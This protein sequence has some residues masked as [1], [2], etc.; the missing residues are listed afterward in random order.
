[1]NMYKE[2]SKFMIEIRRKSKNSYFEAR[3]KERLKKIIES[4]KKLAPKETRTKKHTFQKRVEKFMKIDPKNYSQSE[5]ILKKLYKSTNGKIRNLELLLSSELFEKLCR[6]YFETAD[7]SANQKFIFEDIIY[8]SQKILLN[9]FWEDAFS[10]KFGE[11][12]LGILEEYVAKNGKSEMLKLPGVWELVDSICQDEMSFSF[13]VLDCKIFENCWNSWA[14]IEE[15]DFEVSR[16]RLEEEIEIQIRVALIVSRNFEIFLRAKGQISLKTTEKCIGFLILVLKNLSTFFCTIASEDGFQIAEKPAVADLGRRLVSNL[17][18]DLADLVIRS[19]TSIIIFVQLGES[20]PCL[21]LEF[22]EITEAMIWYFKDYYPEFV[23][24]FEARSTLVELERCYAKVLKFVARVEM[25][26]LKVA[27]VLNFDQK[28]VKDFGQLKLPQKISLLEFLNLNFEI[29]IEC[30]LEDLDKFDF[31]WMFEFSLSLGDLLE[32]KSMQAKESKQDLLFCR[33]T[34]ILYMNFLKTSKPD[35]FYQFIEQ[36]K[37]LFGGFFETF[38][39]VELIINILVEIVHVVTTRHEAPKGLK[40]FFEENSVILDYM[41]SYVDEIEQGIFFPE[42]FVFD[43]KVKVLI[44][45]IFDIIE[46]KEPTEN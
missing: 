28:V 5:K 46:Y 35:H 18:S 30:F 44:R 45:E 20:L 29:L 17:R 15:R 2:R 4:K 22:M 42:G 32:E 23:R 33:E 39:S 40:D 16:E 14:Q 8:Y 7:P 12:F 13:W 27:D 41:K 3:R 37:K 43:G 38:N 1:M 26:G 34:L 6:F 25:S 10:S 19:F 36:N 9:L 11:R 31:D 21:S 24:F